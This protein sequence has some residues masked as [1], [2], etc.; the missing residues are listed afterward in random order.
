MA[1]W[2]FRQQIERP[3][4]VCSEL[5]DGTLMF[6]HLNAGKVDDC[7]MT[8]SKQWYARVPGY[9]R[10]DSRYLFGQSPYSARE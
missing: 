8:L 10:Y 6:K 1:R 2:P 3:K 5:T 9:L 7:A 4:K